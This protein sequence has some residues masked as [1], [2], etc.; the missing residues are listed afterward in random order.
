MGCPYE[1]QDTRG[2]F[3]GAFMESAGYPELQDDNLEVAQ[4]ELPEEG[5]SRPHFHEI[6]TEI[7]Y[8]I[9]GC[10]HL[11]VNGDEIDLSS[12]QFLIVKPGVVLQ[13][14]SNEPGTSVL[15]IKSPSRPDD[16]HYI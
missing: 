6:M 8:V 15:V 1:I 10:L 14:C 16:K 5:E 3:Y 7:T 13:N 12:G 11:V 9:S 2:Y 4:L